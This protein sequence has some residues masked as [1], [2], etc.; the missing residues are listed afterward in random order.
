[1]SFPNGQRPPSPEAH[2]QSRRNSIRKASITSQ[3]STG[4]SDR[5][6][7]SQSVAANGTPFGP[8]GNAQVVIVER[9]PTG[10]GA[11]VQESTDDSSVDH[12]EDET[13]AGMQQD[14]DRPSSRR[15][16]RGISPGAL[17]PAVEQS[18]D[19]LTRMRSIDSRGGVR[20]AEGVV[21]R[22]ESDQR[23][24]DSVP[25]RSSIYTKTAD[26]Y[27]A[28]GVDAGMG[29]K[30]RRLSVLVPAQLE[31]DECPLEEHFNIVNRTRKKHIGEGGAATV[32]MMKSK[33]AG[34]GQK[35]VAVKEFRDWDGNE[36]TEAEYQRKIKSEFAIAKSCY[37]NRNIVETYRLCYSDKQT[38]WYHVME[39]CDQGDLNDIINLGYFSREDRDC[40]FK[41]LLR[42]VDYLHSRGI[43]HRDL[44]SE[45]LLLTDKGCLKIADF[46]TSEVFSGK[47]PGLRHCRRPSLIKD[48]DEIRL[49]KPGLVGSKP[50]MA[51]ELVARQ[52][53]YDPRCTDVWSCAIVYITLILSITP[54]ESAEPRVKN[55]N[56]F[57]TSWDRWRGKYPDG[58]ISEDK[59]L[60]DFASHPKGFSKLGSQSIKAMVMGMLHPDPAKRWSASQALESKEVMEF[61]CCQQDGYSDD[62]KTRQRKVNHN[63]CPPK[64]VKGIGVRV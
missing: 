41:Q 19:N 40:M 24:T 45:N 63:H 56:I 33:T 11:S 31:V 5:R 57:L 12:T 10:T 2:A 47:H 32:K 30:A 39:Y 23:R 6:P 18:E 51:P 42:G 60:P 38:K 59:P 53:D 37:Q 17:P 15:F 4:Q 62:I 50:Y 27:H 14:E 8:H 44:K 61:A 64:K 52:K 36:E 16:S 26:G 35:A 55:Y 20:W 54:W 13:Q 58:V 46:G 34:A 48:G 7:L 28:E 1:V 25:R 3:S 49:C 43:A 21:E 22:R 9:P 29:S